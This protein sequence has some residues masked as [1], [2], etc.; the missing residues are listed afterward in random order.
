MASNELQLGDFTDDQ[1]MAVKKDLEQRLARFQKAFFEKHGRNP[2]E[3]ERDPAKPA[4]KRYRAVCQELATRETAAKTGATGKMA[5]TGGGKGSAAARTAAEQAAMQEQQMKMLV[6]A[7]QQK[8]STSPTP[9]PPKKSA[10]ASSNG[11]SSSSPGGDIGEASQQQKAPGRID[12]CLTRLRS[13]M[14]SAAMTDLLVSWGQFT[15]IFGDLTQSVTTSVAKD[16]PHLSLP[17]LAPWA[18]VLNRSVF[19]LVNIFNLDLKSLQ[20]S[21]SQLSFLSLIGWRESHLA[22]TVLI[23]LVISGITI[24]LLRSLSS[25][26]RLILFTLSVLLLIFGG[27]AYGILGIASYVRGDDNAQILDLNSS[28]LDVVLSVGGIG[29]FCSVSPRGGGGSEVGKG[30][31]ADIGRTEELV[32]GWQAYLGCPHTHTLS[33]SQIMLFFHPI[34][35]PDHVLPPPYPLPPHA[36]TRQIMLFFYEAHKT[37]SK[38]RKYLQTEVDDLLE[39]LAGVQA[40]LET[41]ETHGKRGGGVQEALPNAS[42]LKSMLQ[43]SAHHLSSPPH[44]SSHLLHTSLLVSS[45][46]HLSSPRHSP[47]TNP[48]PFPWQ[49]TQED[50]EHEELVGG[51]AT[52]SAEFLRQMNERAA[53]KKHGHGPRMPKFSSFVKTLLL[54]LILSV[55]ALLFWLRSSRMLPASLLA[56]L[57]DG[58]VD[59]SALAILATTGQR[60]LHRRCPALATS[61]PLT[62]HG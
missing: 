1:L 23:P 13:V 39:K 60:V 31:A 55:A 62:L 40:G 22:F 33:L 29:L 6:A 48:T 26:A 30:G 51:R 47:L 41:V 9:S 43:V 12:R 42:L 28:T 45:S 50:N 14:P 16:F 32:L 8:P 54:W 27:A 10:P 2:N 21:F 19:P 49:P 44:L 34:P 25:I 20:L 24:L 56:G 3:A 59:Y 11:H 37:H 7:A 5:Q 15:A 18:Q 4:I 52:D 36:L 61:P 46:P 53:R 57:P 35:I 58:L 38:I 17:V